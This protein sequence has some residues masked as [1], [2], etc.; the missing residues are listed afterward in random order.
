MRRRFKLNSGQWARLRRVVLVRD[1]WRCAKCGRSG[2]MEV[3]HIKPLHL[4]GAW[5]DLANLQTLCGGPGGCH[6]AKT[7][8]EFR[9]IPERPGYKAKWD[10]LISAL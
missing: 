6:A 9:K 2:R 10:S 7:K 5:Y 4:G 3:D 1:S 8:G